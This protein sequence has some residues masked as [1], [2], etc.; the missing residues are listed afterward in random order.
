LDEPE[1]F[2]DSFVTEERKETQ[3]GA[4]VRK[5]RLQNDTPKFHDVISDIKEFLQPIVHSLARNR[6]FQDTWTAPGPWK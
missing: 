1:V 2:R 3:W 5:S 6:I 4:F